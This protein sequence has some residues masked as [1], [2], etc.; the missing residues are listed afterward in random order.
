MKT[1]KQIIKRKIMIPDFNM[2][3]EYGKWESK[4]FDRY[5]KWYGFN[6]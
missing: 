4:I 5:D 3:V 1:S 6:K 2:E